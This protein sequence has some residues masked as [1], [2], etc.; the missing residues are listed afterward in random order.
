MIADDEIAS[1]LLDLIP[2]DGTPV[3][4]RVARVMIGRRIGRPIE[5]EEYFAARD[6]LQEAGRVGVTR[7]QGGKVFLIA[8]P[9]AIGAEA[10]ATLER[11]DLSE[12]AL[13][14]FL[15]SYL[16][17]G[18]PD[19]LDLPDGSA[20]VVQDVSRAGGKSGQWT[21]PD[22]VLV[23]VARLMFAPQPQVDVHTFELK[24][25]Y[26]GTVQ[27][28]HEALAQT[29]FSHFGHLVWHLPVGSRLEARLD[30]IEQQCVRHGV[31]L[32]L[33][34]DPKVSTACE[35]RV[36]PRRQQT[37]VLDVDGFLASRLTDDN[38]AVLRVALGKGSAS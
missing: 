2:A 30:E 9:E 38:Q 29:R 19:E 28:V 37:S 5:A 33:I 24:A 34:R 14:P 12:A 1:A 35:V 17:H 4:N 22:F 6:R 3:P 36:E 16:R 10:D 31:G 25:E 11:E 8:Q 13:M 26:G 15:D 32:I 27:A 23:S 20:F 21:R 18:F 7:G